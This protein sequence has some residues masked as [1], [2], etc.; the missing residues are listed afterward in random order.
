MASVSWRHSSRSSR[1]EWRRSSTTAAAL[2]RQ[3]M[4]ACGIRRPQLL[5]AI[6][7]VRGPL[8]FRRRRPV[9]WA[10]PWLRMTIFRLV[11]ATSQ[12]LWAP[13][14]VWSLHQRLPCY[15]VWVH[16]GPM[17]F[18]LIMLI[19][20]GAAVAALAA[21]LGP[22][23]QLA[24][25]RRGRRRRHHPPCLRCYP[26]RLRLCDRLDPWRRRLHTSS[27]AILRPGPR[28][29]RLGRLRPPVLEG[30]LALALQQEE[31]CRG[32]CQTLRKHLLIQQSSLRRQGSR[33]RASP[34]VLQPRR[35]W[36]GRHRP[37][38]SMHRSLKGSPLCQTF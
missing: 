36:V 17:L 19:P 4:E 13:A 20:R 28:L 5:L 34:S 29:R 18:K 11:A 31:A 32:G 6:L 22:F 35:W 2:R 15:L 7:V 23:P 1:S 14:P 27:L 30:Y 3:T 25:Q 9:H 38:R 16:S 12:A 8:W 33:P 26:W 10:H 37:Q 24:A 21:A